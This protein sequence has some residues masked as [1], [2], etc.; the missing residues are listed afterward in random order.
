[1]NCKNCG[2]KM[3]LMPWVLMSNPPQYVYECPTC[4]THKNARIGRF[5]SNGE[6]FAIF[7]EDGDENV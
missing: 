7:E 2:E 1:M 4:G 3:R 6:K 5:E